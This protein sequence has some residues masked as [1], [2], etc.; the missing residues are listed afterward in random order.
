MT[1]T[2]VFIY[3]GLVGLLLTVAIYQLT[4]QRKNVEPKHYLIS[5]LQNFAGSFFI[6]SGAVKAIDPLGTAYKMV[7]YFKE[8]ELTFDGTWFSFI[9]PIFPFLSEHTNGFSVFMI[10]LEIVL[11]VMLII[12]FRNKLSA[13]LFFIIVGFFTFLTGFTALTGYVPEDVNFFSFGSWGEFNENNMKVTDCGCFGDFLKLEPFT[14]F[15]KDLF[16]L[17]PAFVFLFRT[18]DMHRIFSN[19]TQ[20][21]IVG[22]TTLL[23][24]LFCFSNYVWDIPVKDFRPFAE[25]V[26]IKDQRAK[27]MDAINSAPSFMLITSKATGE[28]TKLTVEEYTSRYKEFLPKDDFVF[29]Q[30]QEEP[31]M[32][33]SKISEL[34]ITEGSDKNEFNVTED[35]W[36][37]EGYSLMYVCYSLGYDEVEK[38]ISVQD[39]SWVVDSLGVRTVDKIT[40]RDV[41]GKDYTFSDSYKERFTDL[42]NPF[43]EAAQKTGVR[44]YGIAGRAGNKVIQDFRGEVNASYPIYKADD[45]AL[46]TI[47]RSNPGIVLLKNGTIIKKLLIYSFT[48][49]VIDILNDFFRFICFKFPPMFIFSKP[50]HLSF[51]VAT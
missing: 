39:T 40:P 34:S 29:D 24:G 38:M 32:E 3:T 8:F 17:I 14:S 4:R 20:M 47:V 7:D 12:G 25:G 16:L 30:M 27:E 49:C 13:W 26:N 9:S 51:C 33:L 2:Q 46:K 41:K 1:L 28:T 36:D 31:E 48:H 6:F 23:T 50:S 11:G 42:V 35:L 22:V 44:V 21:G 45:I 10:V 43:A 5:F 15:K 19:K 37:H 18:K